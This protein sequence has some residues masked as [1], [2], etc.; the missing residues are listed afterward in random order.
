MTIG[1]THSSS[2][3]QFIKTPDH[4]ENDKH[5]E[6][7]PGNAEI[8]KLNDNEFRITIIKKLNEV[9]ENIEKQFNKFRSYFTRD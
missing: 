9:K 3:N 4:R 7:S 1:K 6:F 2:I 8:S 5:P